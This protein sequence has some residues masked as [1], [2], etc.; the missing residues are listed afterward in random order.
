MTSEVDANTSS[1]TPFAQP[2]RYVTTHNAQGKSV[3]S[4][5]L[6]ETLTTYEIPGMKY[7]EAYKTFQAPIGIN[8]EGDLKAVRSH[9]HEDKEITF[10]EPGNT[11]LR[12]CDWPP[13]GSAPLHRHET[14]DFGIVIHG[15]VEAIMD[16]GESRLLKAGDCIIQ[17]NT[18]HAWR[19]PS[20]TEWVRVLYVIQGVKPAVING[21]EM[22]QDL[23]AFGKSE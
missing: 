2:K 21:R 5:G 22:S 9:A 20:K 23:G 11:I 7:F 15:E 1:N 16:S 18:L 17:R 8:D 4:K 13:G 10:P 14:V 3:F 12:Y 6:E 19:N